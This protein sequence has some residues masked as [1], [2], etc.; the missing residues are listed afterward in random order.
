MPVYPLPNHRDGRQATVSD[1]VHTTEDVKAGRAKRQHRGS[2]IMYRRKAAATAP[3]HPYGSKWY[4][5][6]SDYDCVVLATHTGQVIMA[7]DSRTGWWVV[8]DLGEG[9]GL[10]YHHLRRV[11]VV[12]GAV[13]GEGTPLGFV[14]GNTAEGAYGLWHLHFDVADAVRFDVKD[15]RRMNRLDGHFVDPELHHLKGLRHVPLEE[16]GGGYGG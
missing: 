4:E 13:V 14:G 10:A 15:M 8:L 5:I 1:G 12:P 9:I 6:P 2:D 16:V 7:E 3:Q 11:L